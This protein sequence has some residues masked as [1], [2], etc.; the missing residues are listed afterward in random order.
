MLFHITSWT[1]VI[2]GDT[3]VLRPGP[4]GAE[5]QGVYWSEDHPRPTAAEG[6]TGPDRFTIIA[7]EYPATGWWRTKAGIARKH[8]RP[9][10]RHSQGKCCECR[11]IARNRTE[12]MVAVRFL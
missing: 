12:I 5:G 2:A 7:V 10:T 4:Q 1:G 8:N 11:V 3:F 6:A 9:I